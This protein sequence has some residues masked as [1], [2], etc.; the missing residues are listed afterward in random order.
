MRVPTKQGLYDPKYE[1]DACGIG[2]VIN[3][4]GE[5]TNAIIEQALTV[6]NNLD[7]RG[8]RGNEENTGDGA[9][10]LFQIPDRFFRI[11]AAVNGFSLPKPGEYGV[12][13]IFFCHD[14]GKRAAMKRIVEEEVENQGQKVLGWRVSPVNGE[15]LGEMARVSMPFVEQI[16]IERSEGT[17]DEMAFERRLFVIRRMIEKR[18]ATVDLVGAEYFYIAS[19]SCRTIVYK[20]MLI[21]NQMKKFYLDLND[22]RIESA[23][24]LIHSRF[25]TNTFP[26]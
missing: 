12:G 6:L 8:A 4:N 7:H 9:G 16:F 15:D 10:I 20:G 13:M 14:D 26:S 24:A 17:T 1:H 22:N 25:S 11:Q 23:L 19:M 21:P 5:R 2:A 3:I 18:M